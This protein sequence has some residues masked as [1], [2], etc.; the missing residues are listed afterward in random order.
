MQNVASATMMQFDEEVVERRLTFKP[1]PEI[2]NLCLGYINDIRIDTRTVSKLNE[3]GTE[4]TWEYAGCEFPTL[5]IEFKQVKSDANPKDRYYTFTVKP[6]TTLNKNGEP[7]ETSKIVSI[8]QQEYDR[9]RH[10]ANQF[11]GLKGYPTNAGKCPGLD[12][13][14][15]P[16]TRVAQYK[17]FFEYFVGLIKGENADAPLYK[18]VKLWMKLVADYSTGKFLAFP[19]FVGRGFVERVIQGQNT[20]LEF[21]GNE[22]VNLTKSAKENKRESAIGNTPTAQ[23]SQV[24]PSVQDIIN[25]YM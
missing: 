13:A 20:T 16:A 10:I 14:A 18:G 25:K 2:G 8:M 4:N 17:A 9:L 6:V 15:A 7:V 12:Y 1:D 5:I 23:P 3:D 11:K 24:D 19:G 22:T 21:E